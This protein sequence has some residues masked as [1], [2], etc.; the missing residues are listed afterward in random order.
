MS[1][2]PGTAGNIDLPSVQTASA[3]HPAP[4]C[5]AEVPSPR[6]KRPEHETDHS[7]T[8]SAKLMNELLL[9]SYGI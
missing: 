2:I 3:V 5:V 1:F 4:H 7:L 9:R 8:S 6:L